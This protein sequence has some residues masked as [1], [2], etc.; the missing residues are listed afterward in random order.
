MPHLSPETLTAA[1]QDRLLRVSEPH[2]RDHLIISLALGTGLR[3]GELT[4]LDVGDVYFPGGEPRLRIRVRPEIAKRGRSGDVFLPDALVW[5]LRRFWRHKVQRGE[6]LE[7][8]SPLLCAL[9][10]RRISRRR[11]QVA[12][13]AW[14]VRAG[15]DRLYP[16]HALRHTAVTNVYRA[17]RDLFLAQRFARHASP[18]T[19]TIYTH[20]SDDELRSQIRNIPC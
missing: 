7:P 16:F 6:C 15:F 4:G 2:S 19:T 9:S 10:R 14:Q 12:I 13:R 3:L 1:E 11:I 20:P 18:L 5:K 17:S 8:G